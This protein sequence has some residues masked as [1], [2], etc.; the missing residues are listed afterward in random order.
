MEDN[1]LEE[2]LNK[3]RNLKQYKNKS[4]EELIAIIKAKGAKK[5][6]ISLNW[7]GLSSEEEKKANKLFYAYKKN[8]HLE[9]FSELQDVTKIVNL[10]I[11]LS[12]YYE[13][14]SKYS[15]SGKVLPKYVSD[16][17]NNTV[18]QISDLKTALGLNKQQ[19]AS[20]EEVWKEVNDSLEAE[21]NLHRGAY[22]WVCPNCKQS[23]LLAL[24]VKDYNTFNWKFFRNTQLYNEA[25]FKVFEEKRPI[26]LNDI[27]NFFGVSVDYIEYIYKKIYLLEKEKTNLNKKNGKS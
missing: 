5:S 23:Y 25:M 19:S 1:N 18:R 3:I 15:E 7:A 10:E 4:D 8:Y 2:K 16:S 17:I 21:I 12:R 14:S 20:W 13:I 22:E 9:G 26:T 6:E 11:I 27:A 24:K